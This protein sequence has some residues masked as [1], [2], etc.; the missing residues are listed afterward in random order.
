MP[1]QIIYTDIKHYMNNIFTT[2]VHNIPEPQYRSEILLKSDPRYTF[3]PSKNAMDDE[4]KG[5]LHRN[6]NSTVMPFY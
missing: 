2:K 3:K 1:A 5:L 6:A 4:I